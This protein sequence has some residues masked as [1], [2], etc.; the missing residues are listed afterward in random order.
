MA[1]L[2][3]SLSVPANAFELLL[4][5]LPE[6]NPL[7]DKVYVTGRLDFPGSGRI[8]LTVD[9]ECPPVFL[10]AR[11]APE[12]VPNALTVADVAQGR[13]PGLS[14]VSGGLFVVLRKPNGKRTLLALRRDANAPTAPRCLTEPAGRM[15][16]DLLAVC[17]RE[18]N[19]EII[20]VIQPVSEVRPQADLLIFYSEAGLTAHWNSRKEIQYQ[21]RF[22]H[23]LSGN[24]Q[25]SSRCIPL[26]AG[27][28][29]WT[30][31]PQTRLTIQ[32]PHSTQDCF[33]YAWFDEAHN[34]L[35]FRRFVEIQLKPGESFAF[36]DG[37]AFGRE[38]VFVP[39]PTQDPWSSLGEFGPLTPLLERLSQAGGG[40]H[41]LPL[42]TES[43]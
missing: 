31:L 16:A 24:P 7:S 3:R 2:M 12:S 43:V 33:G 18:A 28:P 20:A 27:V 9:A 22:G 23:A 17:V 38:P 4:A 26:S 34:T 6:T 11:Y 13:A 8:T 25:L 10:N 32:T 42:E 40:E 19:E 39:M 15:D 36:K 5:P 37:E 30:G 21:R 35:E 1:N 29:A 14:L 41:P